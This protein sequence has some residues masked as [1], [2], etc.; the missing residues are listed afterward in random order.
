MADEANPG[1][2]RSSV[3]AA[4]EVLIRVLVLWGSSSSG[5]SPL[6]FFFEDLT[7]YGFKVFYSCVDC[8][9]PAV[10]L[11]SDNCQLM[12]VDVAG[13]EW[14]LEAVLVS[15][16]WCPSV[17]IASWRCV[18][19]EDLGKAMFFHPGHTPSLE[20]VFWQYGFNA[21]NFSLL[22]DL[23]IGDKVAPVDVEDGTKAMLMETLEEFDVAAACDPGLGAVEQ[24]RE[25]SSSV[26]T[27]L[28]LAFQ[29]LIAPHT[30]VE[31]TEGA[32]SLCQSVVNFLVDLSV[33]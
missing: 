5:I 25:Y 33:G 18:T 32:V 19:H 21:G 10:P 14:I 3:V 12:G 20:L 2:V 26:N 17:S 28:G 29:A 1:Q 4:Y 7:A 15:I 31:S 6:T 11:G 30:L 27:D 8:V 9:A 13:L 23:D 24:S 22:E 16:L